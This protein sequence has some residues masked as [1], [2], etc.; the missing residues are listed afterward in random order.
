VRDGAS[1]FLFA[2]EPGAWRAF[3]GTLPS[4]ARLCAMGHVAQSAVDSLTWERTA[5][6]YLRVCGR[7]GA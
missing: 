7:L 2:N 5:A 3:L 6:E 1:G 4:R